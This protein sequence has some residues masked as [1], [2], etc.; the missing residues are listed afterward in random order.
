LGGRGR[1]IS[2]FKASLVYKV[3][4]R[5]ARTI[6]RNPVLEEKTKKNKKTRCMPLIPSLRRQSRWISEFEASLDYRVSSKTNRTT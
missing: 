2:E 4:S 5:T 1:Q 6:Q 3:S